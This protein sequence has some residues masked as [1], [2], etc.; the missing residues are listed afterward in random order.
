MKFHSDRS[1]LVR[2]LS[3]TIQVDFTTEKI[4]ANFS[5]YSAWHFRSKLLRELPE[6]SIEKVF[7]HICCN[8]VP[9]KCLSSGMLH[10]EE[11]SSE[12]EFVRQAFFTE[13]NDQSGW[14]YHR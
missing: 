5:N 3:D 11:L 13:P 8:L 12:L 6:G 7:S 14:F 4:N 1:L 2:G 10:F 9:S